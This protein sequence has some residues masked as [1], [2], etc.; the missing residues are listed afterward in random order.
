M[1]YKDYFMTWHHYALPELHGPYPT[2]DC[3]K[4]MSH[5]QRDND[6][7]AAHLVLTD[8]QALCWPR[9]REEDFVE[10]PTPSEFGL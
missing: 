10:P 8:A 1:T 3:L 9:D 6:E 5:W 7:R 4:R 2:S